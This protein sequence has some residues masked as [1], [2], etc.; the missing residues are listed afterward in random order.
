LESNA[1]GTPTG[2]FHFIHVDDSDASKRAN[3]SYTRIEG[4]T[5]FSGTANSTTT[6]NT[7]SVTTISMVLLAT[8]NDKTEWSDPTGNVTTDIDFNYASGF[9]GNGVIDSNRDTSDD[10]SDSDDDLTSDDSDSNDNSDENDDDSS[11]GDAGAGAGAGSSSRQIWSGTATESGTFSVNA[12]ANIVSNGS[13]PVATSTT[14]TKNADDTAPAPEM[15]WTTIG[16]QNDNFSNIVAFERFANSKY[17]AD[18]LTGVMTE[19]VKSHFNAGG[20]N[21]RELIGEQWKQTIGHRN[22]NV[23]IDGEN[24]FSAPGPLTQDNLTGTL[25]ILSLGK[26]ILTE[27]T[28][29]D[30]QAASKKWQNSGDRDNNSTATSN[31]TVNLGGTEQMSAGPANVIATIAVN[32]RIDD[33]NAT[34]QKWKFATQSDLPSEGSELDWKKEIDTLHQSSDYVFRYNANGTGSYQRTSDRETVF[35]TGTVSHLYTQVSQSK[36][37][38]SLDPI[39]NTWTEDRKTLESM[40]IDNRDSSS[41]LGSYNDELDGGIIAGLVAESTLSNFLIESIEKKSTRILTPVAL[42]IDPPDTGDD[43]DSDNDGTDSSDDGSGDDQQDDDSQNDDSQDDSDSEDESMDDG[44]TPTNFNSHT[45]SLSVSM[46][47]KSSYD[48]SGVGAFTDGHSLTGSILE[49]GTTKFEVGFSLGSS[50]DTN[51]RWQLD[52]SSMVL[53]TVASS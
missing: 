32:N 11:D 34:S 50:I 20:N 35:G 27:T 2:N 25:S 14:Q 23:K 38:R 12:H 44:V 9:S 53:R 43:D 48:R 16:N 29:N 36:L 41:G 4:D 1:I 18:N 40:S 33:T 8:A 5:E 42:E 7:L 15:I 19:T 37:D 22:S 45:G 46:T 51:G 31:V 6:E 17:Q 39:A 49:N 26:S 24:T 10:D 28:E 3:G 47:V 13:T 52:G 21:A 30:Y